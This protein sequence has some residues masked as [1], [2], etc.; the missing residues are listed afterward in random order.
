MP[1]SDE[2]ATMI[3]TD[4]RAARIPF[5]DENGRRVDFHALR[6]TCG[7]WM[8]AAKVHPKLIQEH[9]RHSTINL[10]MNRYTHVFK[11]D[12]AAAVASLPTLAPESVLATGTDGAGDERGKKRDTAGGRKAHTP[13]IHMESDR[14]QTPARSS[15]E[16]AVSPCGAEKK[17]RTGANGR[18]RIRTFVGIFPADLQSAPVG[19]LGTRP[20][21]RTSVGR[22]GPLT[23]PR[24]EM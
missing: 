18:G 12:Q 13:G 19:H 5:Q 11:R 9:M 17:P 22:R 1:A 14:V 16:T 15:G 8:A 2:T 20:H 3:R 7:S 23:T 21:C 10:T 6:H 24:A 4:L